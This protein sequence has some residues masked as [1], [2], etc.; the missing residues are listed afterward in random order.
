M[1]SLLEDGEWKRIW[2]NVHVHTHKPRHFYSRVAFTSNKGSTRQRVTASDEKNEGG[3]EVMNSSDEDAYEPEY[4]PE[5][6]TIAGE[7]TLEV[8]SVVRK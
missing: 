3:R 8:L 4:E 5:R 2:Q 7:I 6:I 1:R